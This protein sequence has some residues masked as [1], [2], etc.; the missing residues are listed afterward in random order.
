MLL[1][2]A[3]SQQRSYPFYELY[4]LDSLARASSPGRHFGGLYFRF[5]SLVE[6][7][8]EDAD[9]STRRL[10]RHFE[11]VFA[12]FYI[13]AC[14]AYA[15]KREIPLPAWRAYFRDSSLSMVQ[16]YLLGANAHLNGGLAEAIAGSYTPE[17]WKILKKEY[18]LFN[19]CLNETLRHVYNETI[20]ASGRARTLSILSLGLTA[21]LSNY[22]MYKWRKRQMRVT[23]YFFAG[24]RRYQKLQLKIDRKKAGIDETIIKNIR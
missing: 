8:L 1:Q 17:Q 24:D 11:Q 14:I 12:R 18:V 23:E 6:K 13:D 22:Y 10:V 21:P 15:A 9:S 16:Y 5:L 7:K 19:S 20:S 4:Q 3:I 2:P